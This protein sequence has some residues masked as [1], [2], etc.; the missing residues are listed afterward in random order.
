MDG[1]I[2]GPAEAFAALAKL[3]PAPKKTRPTSKAQSQSGADGGDADIAFV[4]LRPV[5]IKGALVSEICQR[6]ERRGLSLA[7]M[8]MVKPGVELAGEH[9]KRAPK[10]ELADLVGAIAPGPV[11][12][13]LWKGSGAL[14]AAR[15][16]AGDAD[17]GR[18]QPGTIRGDL[19]IPDSGDVL[20]ELAADAAE[21]VRLRDLWFEE[22]ALSASAASLAAAPTARAKAAPAPTP[23]P[24]PPPA[25]LGTYYITTAIN[26]ANGPPHMGHAYEAVAADVIARY[27]RAYGREVYFLTGADEHGQKIADTAAGQ[28]IKPIE[29]CDKHVR[30]FQARGAPAPCACA[31]TLC[32][33]ALCACT[34]GA[35]R[36]A[37]GL[38]TRAGA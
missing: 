9:Y 20:V 29:L 19:S 6:F 23:P 2:D 4:L 30:Q 13:T 14:S 7:A 33:C 18:A 32:A 10:S 22:S 37:D 16:L 36:L 8:R 11:L 3:N 35:Q 25:K 17:L 12:V 24:R 1:P 15:V 21:A 27:H 38:A 5:V 34:H 28:G 26:Y 31:S